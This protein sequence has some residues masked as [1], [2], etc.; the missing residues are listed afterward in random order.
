MLNDRS[1]LEIARLVWKRRGW[2]ILPVIAGLG[3]GL[4]AAKLV[5]P[6]YRASTAILVESPRVPAHYVETTVTMSLQDRL[7]TIEQEIT[8]RGNLERILNEMNLYPELVA[9]GAMERALRRMQRALTVEVRGNRIFRVYFGARDPQLAAD[10]ANR[11]AQLFIQENL[12]IREQQA[13]STSAFLEQELGDVQGRLEEQE[14]RVARFTIR[15]EGSLPEQ[16]DS[17]LASLAHAQTRLNMNLEATEGAEMR[18]ALLQRE[19]AAGL[20][21]SETGPNARRRAVEIELARLQALYTERHPDVVRL[22]NELANLEQ[23]GVA[24]GEQA[25]E[26]PSAVL[27]PVLQSE[28]DAV[29]MD[30]QRLDVER[31]RLLAEIESYQGRLT[32]T[33]RVEQE[34]LILTRDYDNINESYHSLLEKRLDSRLAENL[35]K[36]RQS[37]QFRILEGALPPKNPSFP[38]PLLFL[39]VG[40]AAGGLVGLGLVLLREETDTTFL[41]KE[42][43]QEA[44]PAVEV[45]AVL[46]L[47]KRRRGGPLAALRPA[48]TREAREVS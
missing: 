5:S 19:A 36:K 18:R 8:S 28:I 15:N 10:T 43:L 6:I 23:Q 24:A 22:K 16:R 20:G 25:R 14:A 31:Q 27:D 35:E 37:E 44:F 39:F 38:K 29:D 1:A 11:I 13:Q 33:P 21:P 4:L 42:M 45:L 2:M 47:V 41:D 12:R 46:P 7:Q 48:K 32:R 34:L 9:E 30:I 26:R 17:N 40:A 3:V